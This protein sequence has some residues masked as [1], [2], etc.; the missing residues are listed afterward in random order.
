LDEV[1][2]AEFREDKLVGV[3]ARRIVELRKTQRLLQLGLGIC[4]MSLLLM[5]VLYVA[6]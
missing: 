5:V 4:V 3:L 1:D 6:K 2:S